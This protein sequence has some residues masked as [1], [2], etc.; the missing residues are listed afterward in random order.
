MRRRRA[1]KRIPQPDI[2]YNSKVVGELI[3]MI[4]LRGK[5]SVAERI[6]YGALDLAAKKIGKNEPLE[7]L[8]KALDN[9][10]PM[11]ELK[12]RRVGGATYQVPIEVKQDRA[13]S[14]GLR[15]IR[16]YSRAKKG[17]PMQQR[18]AD[19]L[20]EA[21]RGEGASVKKKQDTHKMAEANKAFS[22]FR[23]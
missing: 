19:E 17:K 20:I 5:R 3:N 1:E 16:N 8:N 7:V 18:L 10:K 13:V 6:V 21:Y 23:W 15:W 12:S 2:K 11:L 14:L 9:V 4:M 22:H